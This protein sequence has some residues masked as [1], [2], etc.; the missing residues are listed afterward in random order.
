MKQFWTKDEMDKLAEM[1]AQGKTNTQIAAAL[2]R[3]VA[4]SRISERDCSATRSRRTSSALSPIATIRTAPRNPS[5]KTT[6]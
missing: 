6:L 1:A 5:R 2:C 4:R 3:S